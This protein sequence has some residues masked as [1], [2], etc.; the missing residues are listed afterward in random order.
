MKTNIY[1][2]EVEYDGTHRD[3]KAKLHELREK[4]RRDLILNDPQE[5]PIVEKELDILENVLSI[6]IDE[7][8]ST[9]LKNSGIII[10][11]SSIKVTSNTPVVLNS[12]TAASDDE[13]IEIE[14]NEDSISILFNDKDQV[15]IKF[16][17]KFNKTEEVIIDKV[18]QL[19][20]DK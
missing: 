15:T 2:M 9:I 7:L 3:L 11:K 6:T 1:G 19:S 20:D 17:I 13:T 18:I 4:R 8:N 12:I 10:D 5:A 16:T 14:Q